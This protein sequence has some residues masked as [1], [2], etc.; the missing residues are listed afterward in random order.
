[1]EENM[2]IEIKDKCEYCLT[3]NSF[4]YDEHHLIRRSASGTNKGT[5]L[6]CRRCHDRTESS[7]W[8]YLHLQKVF[9]HKIKNGNPR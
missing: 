5:V 8:F 7:N 6:L 9:K 2:Y 4:A 1:M 3:T